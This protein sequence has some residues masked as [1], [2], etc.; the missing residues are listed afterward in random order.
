MANKWAVQDGN[1]SDGSTWNDGVIPTITD[2]VYCNN[3]TITIPSSIEAKTI[4]NEPKDSIVAG[5]T[6]KPTVNTTQTINADLVAENAVLVTYTTLCDYIINGNVKGN[7]T[8]IQ[9]RIN[10]SRIYKLTING[11][12]TNSLCRIVDETWSDNL[13]TLNIIINGN[14]SLSENHYLLT[15]DAGAAHNNIVIN[16]N[17]DYN[18]SSLVLYAATS[19]ANDFKYCDLVISGKLN[20]VQSLFLRK[21]EFSDIEMFQNAILSC[22]PITTSGKIKLEN[23]TQL[24]SEDI[25]SLPQESDVKQG[26]EYG[27]SKTGTYDPNLPQPSTVLK[28]VEYGD[29]QKGTLE[30]IALTGATATADNISVVN[31]T[32]QEVERVKNCATVSTMQ[33][34]FE[35]FKEE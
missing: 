25:M 13:S 20:V 18:S 7:V 29:N 31:L 11:N 23:N 32:E 33:Q 1:W 15:R 9:Q 17:M 5:G 19:T 24:A 35:N 8:V 12:V 34:C 22:R 27:I 4:S 10:S 26:V 30:V 28:D 14:C 21:L 2:D 6:I 16:G 3:K